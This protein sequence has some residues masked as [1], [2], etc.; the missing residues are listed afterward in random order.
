MKT[1]LALSAALLLA[2][3]AY[4]L[5]AHAQTAPQPSGAAPQTQSS[6][7]GSGSQSSQPY[8]PTG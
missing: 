7:Y 8:K 3:S 4:A 2:G 5:P 1:T 6:V